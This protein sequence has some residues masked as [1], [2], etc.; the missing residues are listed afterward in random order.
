[1]SPGDTL[2]FATDGISTDFRRELVWSLPPQNA[3]ERILAR[4]GKTTDD[5]LVL[6]ARYLPARAVAAGL[7]GLEATG[8]RGFP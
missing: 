1:V 3:A 7:I 8:R 5:A 4:H 6:V 2:V